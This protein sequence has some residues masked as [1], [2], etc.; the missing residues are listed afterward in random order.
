MLIR[1]SDVSPNAQNETK[2]D[3]D[4]STACGGTSGNGCSFGEVGITILDNGNIIT[5]R[6]NDCSAVDAQTLIDQGDGG[7]NQAVAEQRLGVISTVLRDDT[8]KK[9]PYRCR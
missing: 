3:G 8:T 7:S 2:Q 5:D 6:D 1:C 4:R 9:A